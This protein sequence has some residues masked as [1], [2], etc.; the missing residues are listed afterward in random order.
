MGLRLKL[1][2]KSL[3]SAN[4]NP[5]RSQDPLPLLRWSPQ[6]RPSLSTESSPP[7]QMNLHE[8]LPVWGSMSVSVGSDPNKL[9]PSHPASLLNI[10]HSPCSHSLGISQ[11]FFFNSLCPQGLCRGLAEPWTWLALQRDAFQPPNPGNACRSPLAAVPYA[12]PAVLYLGS[13]Q[14]GPDS[15][16]VYPDI[17]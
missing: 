1:G 11:G 13:P 17:L 4:K 12:C 14:P 9:L 6:R 16:N 10:S 2:E 15:R 7:P 5:S 8:D 3:P